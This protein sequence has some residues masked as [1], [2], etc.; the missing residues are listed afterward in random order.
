MYLPSQDAPTQASFNDWVP[1]SEVIRDFQ[2]RGIISCC[3]LKYY[4]QNYQLF[5]Q[6]EWML[7]FS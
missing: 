1:D 2:K 5:H 4:T 3:S 7:T 6:L